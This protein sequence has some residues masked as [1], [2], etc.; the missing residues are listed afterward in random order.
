[1]QRE[2]GRIWQVPP[3][4]G[5]TT[6]AARSGVTRPTISDWAARSGVTRLTISDWA[7]RSGVTRPTWI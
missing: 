1:M 7:A 4:R 3:A 5:P 6:F 2:G